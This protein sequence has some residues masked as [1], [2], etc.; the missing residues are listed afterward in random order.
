MQ[1]WLGILML[2]GLLYIGIE[3]GCLL[4]ENKRLREGVQEIDEY[5]PVRYIMIGAKG[6][7]H[8]ADLSITTVQ[9]HSA[10]GVGI[11]CIYEKDEEKVVKTFFENGDELFIY[12]YGVAPIDALSKGQIDGFIN[13]IFFDYNLPQGAERA[14]IE[15]LGL[16]DYMVNIGICS[17]KGGK[18]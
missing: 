18:K 4:R 8:I 1:I 11:K 17:E 13:R 6:S 10:V 7:S 16:V 15:Q 3:Y 14:V 12:Q 5:T 9:A 2:L